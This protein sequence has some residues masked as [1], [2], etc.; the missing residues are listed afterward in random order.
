MR[1]PNLIILILSLLLLLSSCQSSR[2]AFYF[3]FRPAPVH[4]VP[5]ATAVADSPRQAALAEP[6]STPR[7]VIPV[8]PRHV[9]SA[10]TRTQRPRQQLA[11]RPLVG[12]AMA[13]AT[14]RPHSNRRFLGRNAHQHLSAHSQQR[15]VDLDFSLAD[16]LLALG[17]VALV[18]I[19]VALLLKVVLGISF[20]AALGIIVLIIVLALVAL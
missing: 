8:R 3:V 18:L 2:P 13:A 5:D 16:Y 10:M 19:G 1:L 17:L 11:L 9:A 4:R 6:A 20:L 14:K 15:P 7:V 12:Q